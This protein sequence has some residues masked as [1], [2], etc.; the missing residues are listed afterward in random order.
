MYRWTAADGR[1]AA[2]CRPGDVG[3]RAGRGGMAVAKGTEVRVY[4]S[5]IADEGYTVLEP[6]SDTAI[7]LRGACPRSAIPPPWLDGGGMAFANGV[8][9][10]LAVVQVACEHLRDGG[11]GIY[12]A[13]TEYCISDDPEDLINDA[14]STSTV[15]NYTVAVDGRGSERNAVAELVLYRLTDKSLELVGGVTILRIER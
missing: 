14:V 11:R 5:D 7:F 10:E 4:W 13:G 15:G 3:L 6:A 9:D 8:P 1:P 12:I 2:A